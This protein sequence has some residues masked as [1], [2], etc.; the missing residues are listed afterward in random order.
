[1]RVLTTVSAPSPRRLRDV[2]FDGHCE[3]L[4]LVMELGDGKDL[5]TEV[6]RQLGTGTRVAE[7]EAAN[8]FAQILQGVG[9]VHGM[10]IC[11]RDLKLENVVLHSDGTVKVADFGM[12]KDFSQSIVETRSQIGTLAYLAPGTL[13]LCLSL[14]LSLSLSVSLSVRVSLCVS[15]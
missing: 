6:S 13:S 1:M 4:C 12:S 14:S 9:F 11:H 2:L 15:V 3:F 8:W 5:F 7:S 10:G